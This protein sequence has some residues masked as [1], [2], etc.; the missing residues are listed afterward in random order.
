MT[1]SIDYDAAAR[2]IEKDGFAV[3]RSLLS[4]ERIEQFRRV[5][6]GQFQ[7]APRLEGKVYK[8]GVTPDYVQP[9]VIDSQRHQ[10][11][12]YRLYQFY[13]NT[14][15]ANAQHIIDTIIELRNR[16]EQKW[17]EIQEY[18][19]KNN[20]TDY[21]IVAKYAAE[22]GYQSKHS[23]MEASLSHPALQCEILLTQ[24]GRDYRGGD[25]RLYPSDG[26]VISTN[27]DLRVR[28]GDLI[29]FDKRLEHDVTDTMPMVGGKGR[30]MALIGAKTFPRTPRS[31]LEDATVK[32]RR[33]FF[34][35]TPKLYKIVRTL[36]AKSGLKAS[37]KI[38]QNGYTG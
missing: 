12:S 6:E 10:I 32:T 28:V 2:A 36:A 17:P 33:F 24:P 14:H 37:G 27:N 11:A 34:L 31:F 26:R 19:T 16:I 18:N 7:G 20:F 15:S 9:W 8:P 25:L 1:A 5:C 4:P 35:R 23:D 22:G 30:W 29:L 38:N 3:V 21:N 13:H